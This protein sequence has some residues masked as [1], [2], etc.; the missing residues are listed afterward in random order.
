MRRTTLL[1]TA[2]ALASTTLV[3]PAH[4]AF[5]F[6]SKAYEIEANSFTPP[7]TLNGGLIVRPCSSCD[8][9]RLRVTGDTTYTFDGEQMSLYRFRDALSR[10]PADNLSIGVLHHLESDT[11]LSIFATLHA[12]QTK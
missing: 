5:E 4:A 1:L 3:L 8:S 6:V 11:V 7:T 9:L 10:T 12:E 2:L